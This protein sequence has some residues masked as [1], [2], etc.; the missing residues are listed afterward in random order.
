MCRNK[1]KNVYKGKVNKEKNC[2]YINA[3]F[4]QKAS[5]GGTG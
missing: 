3:Y 1:E 5:F 2:L 4:C